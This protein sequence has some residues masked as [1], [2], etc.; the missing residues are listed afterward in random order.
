MNAT[1]KFLAATVL[2]G[3]AILSG[4]EATLQGIQKD[5]NGTLLNKG[6][7]NARAFFLQ[8]FGAG[9]DAINAIPEEAW[10]KELPQKYHQDL[11]I[12]LKEADC[13]KYNADGVISPGGKTEQALQEFLAINGVELKEGQPLVSAAVYQ[14]AEIATGKY[15]PEPQEQVLHCTLG[16]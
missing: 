1:Q 3:T 5:L 4:C 15:G 2:A 9:N 12:M 6:F 13:Y 11:Q 16:K 14:L 8:R 10:D 7:N